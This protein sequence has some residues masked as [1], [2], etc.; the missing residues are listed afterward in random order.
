VRKLFFALALASACAQL[1]AATTAAQTSTAAAAAQSQRPRGKQG[2]LWRKMEEE[3]LKLAGES[4]AVVGV[5]VLD[6][7]S[8]DV[9]LHNADEVFAAASSIKIA[10]LAE[11]YRQ[12]ERGA[13]GAPG[14]ARL[15]DLYTVNARDL[16]PGSDIMQGLTPG[17]TRLTNRDLATF[18]VAVSDNA[19]TN[20]LISRLGMQNVNAML[21]GLGL[22][23]TRLRRWMLDVAAAVE[24]RE[25]TSTPREMVRLLEALYRARVF[26]NMLT[27]DFFRLLST[28][29]EGYLTALLPEGVRV[30]NKPGWLEAVRTDSGVVYAKNRPFAVSVTTAYARDERAARDAIGRIA[31]AAYH[32]FD[33]AG[34]ASPYGRVVSPR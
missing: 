17:T 28:N 6:L 7:T 4:S 33:L 32:Y 24:G 16:I 25:N 21:D 15:A 2:L 34:R 19:A 27:E 1:T 13:G 12:E 20:V 9:M 18:M 23:E 29:K 3:I 5:A 31:L 26:K 30:A 8:G 14:Q 10:V 11:L 22:K